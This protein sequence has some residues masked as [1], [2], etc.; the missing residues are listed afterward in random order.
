MQNHITSGWVDV[1]VDRTKNPQAQHRHEN[2][3]DMDLWRRQR[4][5]ATSRADVEVPRD[6]KIASMAED[7]SS[8]S[9][10]SNLGYLSKYHTSNWSQVDQPGD[11][12]QMYRHRETDPSQYDAS[13]GLDYDNGSSSQGQGSSAKQYPCIYNYIT[14]E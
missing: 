10:F 9:N 14:C 3:N 12:Y 7:R 4:H 1:I 8:R 11:A 2:D 5:G 13:S 6:D